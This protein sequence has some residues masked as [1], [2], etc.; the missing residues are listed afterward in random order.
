[1][2]NKKFAAEPGTPKPLGPGP[3]DYEEDDDPGS[4]GPSIP[5]R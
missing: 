5:D 2:E 1:M 3:D 4:R